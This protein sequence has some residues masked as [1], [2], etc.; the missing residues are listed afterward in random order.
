MTNKAL[1]Q[2]ALDALLG[3]KPHSLTHAKEQGSAIIALREAIAQPAPTLPTARP[4]LPHGG[5]DASSGY[6]RDRAFNEGF[7]ACLAEIT[8]IAQ[9][10]LPD[11]LE[12]TQ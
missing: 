5:F 2:Q 11:T 1:L 6:V 7:N 4:V 9:P 3:Y 10:A 8:A 12:E